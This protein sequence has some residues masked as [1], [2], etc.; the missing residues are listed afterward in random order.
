[1]S[2]NNVI[3]IRQFGKKFK[4]W[5]ADMDIAIEHDFK[6]DKSAIEYA[7]L[8]EACS[9]AQELEKYYGYIEYGIKII[10]HNISE[11]EEDTN[12]R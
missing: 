6:P 8:E 7:T 12:G 11:T 4:V 1:M 5:H 3:V 2:A 9:K 10:S